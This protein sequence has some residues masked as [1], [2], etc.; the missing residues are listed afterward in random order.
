MWFRRKKEVQ[1][2]I[3]AGLDAFA[4]HQSHS[5]VVVTPEKAL[6]LPA[7][8][9][10][11]NIIADNISSLPID[12]TR[13]I[14]DIAE[15][16]KTPLWAESPNPVK[17]KT[18]FWREFVHCLLIHGN[19]FARIIRNQAGSVTALYVL[20]PA[21]CQVEWSEDK[22]RPVF[23]YDGHEYGPADILHVADSPKP[24]NLEGVPRL[25]R[26]REAIGLALAAEEFGARFFKDGAMYSGVISHPGTPTP[27]ESRI[28]KDGFTKKHQGLH[29]AHAIGVLTGGAEFKPTTG[30][31]QSSQYLETR[32]HQ[33]REIANLFGVPAYM[34][35]PKVNSSWGSG[36][37][38]QR[39]SFIEDTLRPWMDLVEA[40]VT[41]SL[42]PRGQR[43]RFN[44]D[45]KL[46]TSTQE[47]YEAYRTAL[48]AGIMTPNEARILEDLPPMGGGDE[49]Y[50]P[51]NMAPASQA[52]DRPQTAERVPEGE[53]G[54]PERRASL[55]GL[56]A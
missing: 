47:R 1:E 34:L 27:E 41:K 32:E 19:A 9:R 52:V 28:L 42:L 45:A 55:S 10:C 21:M 33:N 46:R 15:P 53:Q 26:A 3:E 50:V 6:Q 18:A 38:E 36:V 56:S 31:Q 17:S 20:E 16:V 51:L 13:Q 37:A 2:N 4:A 14:G 48:S 11:V 29:K 23:R 12:I 35:D 5:G 54:S 44:A 24:G 30:D 22:T 43:F 7:V 25:M 8:Q 39:R 49:L 40:A